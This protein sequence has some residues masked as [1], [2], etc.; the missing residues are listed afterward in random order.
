MSLHARTL[1]LLKK[2]TAQGLSLR[3][4]AAKSGGKVDYD[5]LRKF[6]AEAATDP[7]V[8]RVEGLHDFLLTLPL[9]RAA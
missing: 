3:Q 1:A 9:T 5:W 7:G 6:A 8:N 4:I 2:H